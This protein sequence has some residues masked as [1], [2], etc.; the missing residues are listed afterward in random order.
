MDET[1]SEVHILNVECLDSW[2]AKLFQ[3]AA[4]QAQ[5]KRGLKLN[6][7]NRRENFGIHR[8]E[9]ISNLKYRLVIQ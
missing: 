9:E 6:I 4:K 1:Q 7:Q 5:E 8:W 2:L 3:T